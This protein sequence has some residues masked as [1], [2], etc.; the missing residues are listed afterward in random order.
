MTVSGDR[1]RGRHGLFSRAAFACFVAA[2]LAALLPDFLPAQT[3]EQAAVSSNLM[4][5]S[6]SVPPGETTGITY[7]IPVKGMI[8]KGLLTYVVRKGLAEAVRENAAAVIFEMDTPGGLVESAEDIV[9]LLIDLP[10]TIRTYTLV[11]K[12]ALSAGAFIAMATDEI[13]MTPGSRIGASALVLP[14][15]EIPEGDIKEKALSATYA[16]IARAAEAKG[17]DPKLV[18]AMMRKEAVYSIGDEI[19]CPAGELLTLTDVSALR[20]VGEGEEARPLL[21]VGVVKN[22]DELLELTGRA[23]T[24]VVMLEITW[25][26]K[27]ARW[28][29]ALRILFL[30]GGL[31]GLYI[32]IKTPGFGVPGILGLLLLIVFFWGHLVAGLAGME[33]LLLFA[34]GAVL[35]AVEIL[36]IPG[37]GF[38]GIAGILCMIGALI[39]AMVQHNP[40]APAYRL[41]TMDLQSSMFSMAA[42]MVVT[43]GLILVLARFLPKSAIFQRIVL[44]ETSAPGGTDDSEAHIGMTGTALTPLHPSGAGE[45]GGA[46]LSV[47]ARGEFIDA[48]SPIVIAETHGN[49]IV[50]DRTDHP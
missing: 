6:G 29:A 13:Y 35:L 45:F 4:I 42:A 17:Y 39:L 18:E 27:L 12:D 31:F 47:V 21:A 5:K 15:G 48:G 10:P 28:I 50:V 33:E 40:G 49:R 3:S 22:L 43:G 30:A 41:P 9:R 36:L 11:N 44:A 2:F 37:F 23:K 14:W 34:V 32:E 8:E 26:E 16:L 1:P 7:V 38:V 19:I 20:M 46:R 25:S 24:N